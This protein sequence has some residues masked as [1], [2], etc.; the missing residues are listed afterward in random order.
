MD[1]VGHAWFFEREWLTAFWRELP[2]PDLFAFEGEPHALCAG[3]DMHFSYTLQKYLGLGT[4]VPPHPI[5]DRSLW[6]SDPDLAV[7]YGTDGAAVSNL[8]QPH[9]K[10]DKAWAYYRARGFRLLCETPAAPES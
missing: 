4:Y 10:F 1:Y 6:G 5:A 3:E 8:R 9:W 7:T 2:S